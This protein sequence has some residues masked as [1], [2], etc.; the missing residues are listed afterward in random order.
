MHFFLAVKVQ[1]VFSVRK[2]NLGILGVI[3]KGVEEQDVVFM[4]NSQLMLLRVT[5]VKLG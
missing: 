1:E 3:F 5:G 2:V 4:E